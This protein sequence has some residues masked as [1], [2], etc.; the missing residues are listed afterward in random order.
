MN[1]QFELDTWQKLELLIVQDMVHSPLTDLA[2]ILLPGATPYE[3]EGTF[4][5]YKGRI[6]RI[7][8]ILLPPAAA[9]A[10]FEILREISD[11]FDLPFCL[12]PKNAFS[13]IAGT[14]NGYGGADYAQLGELGIFKGEGVAETASPE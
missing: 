8:R 10:D 12:H 6:Q 9:K 1:A 7:R 3:K 5:N 14:V 4:T 11:L 2:N 13:E